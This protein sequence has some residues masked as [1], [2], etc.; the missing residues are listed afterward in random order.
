MDDVEEL[1]CA[2]VKATGCESFQALSLLLTGQVPGFVSSFSSSAS[3]L[4]DDSTDSSRR[5]VMDVS[6]WGK[7]IRT[8]ADG[9]SRSVERSHTL[10]TN[11]DRV[12]RLLSWYPIV[13]YYLM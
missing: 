5:T 6:S 1:E 9:E 8:Q 11:G 4:L 13:A 3:S 12:E 10:Q 2:Y 7:R